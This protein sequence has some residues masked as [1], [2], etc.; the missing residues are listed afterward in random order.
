MAFSITTFF[1]SLSSRGSRLALRLRF[2]DAA[3]F[4][5]ARVSSAARCGEGPSGFRFARLSLP[6]VKPMGGYT[7]RAPPS[8]AR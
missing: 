1:M 7:W 5:P 2:A 6:G 4:I 3:L 8:D